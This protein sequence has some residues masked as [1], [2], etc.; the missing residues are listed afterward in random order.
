MHIEL[1]VSGQRLRR[2]M[3]PVIVGGSRYYLTA[4]V[5]FAGTDW[6]GCQVWLKIDQAGAQNAYLLDADG[7]VTA[8][9]GINLPAGQYTMSLLGLRDEVLITTNEVPLCVLKSGADGGDPLPEIPQTAAEQIALMAQEAVDTAR[10]VRKDADEGRFNGKDGAPGKAGV[11]AEH[12]WDG[13]V[14]TIT[15]A[16]GT[17]S[18]DLRGPQG[19]QG[20]EGKQGPQGPQGQ[21]G[22]DAPQDAVRY[23]VQALT[24]EEQETARGNIGAA[25]GEE[26]SRVKDD[27]DDI[28]ERTYNVI[29]GK[30][31]FNPSDVPQENYGKYVNPTGNGDIKENTNYFYSY[32]INLHGAKS[33]AVSGIIASGTALEFFDSNK[34]RILYIPTPG[35]DNYVYSDIPSNAKYMRF[36]SRIDYMNRTM[37]EFGNEI[38]SY[39]SYIDDKYIL[40]KQPFYVIGKDKNS[41]FSTVTECLSNTDGDITCYVK[42]G[43]YEETI[44]CYER[45][46]NI[47]GENKEYC[48]L[49]NT[50]G[51]YSTPPVWITSGKLENLTIYSKNIGNV[52]SRSG[53]AV[54]IDL[55]FNDDLEKRKC[56]ISNCIIISDYNNAI[57][58]GT[59]DGSVYDIHDCDLITTAQGMECF[60]V[61]QG[62]GQV[63]TSVI[64]FNRN[65]LHAELID[66]Q[67]YTPWE[68]S[69]HTAGFTVS[70]TCKVIVNATNNIL[71]RCSDLPSCFEYGDRNYGNS[72]SKMNTLTGVDY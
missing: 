65:I 27:L 2:E 51:E 41:D 55:H 30:N 6:D 11:S 15:S 13:T 69:F 5:A 4:H 29:L 42:C 33:I 1:S 54:H 36:S 7:C 17:S 10:S 48:I 23:G 9:R 20:P 37:V 58:C 47:I 68:I 49:C 56:E 60:K 31:R 34:E 62:N 3:G 38:T 22:K 70:E 59:H 35:N 19:P 64:N 25:S 16:S 28:K 66:G 52:P 40:S 50:S 26:L 43:E 63:G 12:Q 39:V 57:G 45:T 8:D 71:F 32:L 24:D 53:Y 44:A 72:V 61:H 21:A 46:V 14:L 18:A 67:S